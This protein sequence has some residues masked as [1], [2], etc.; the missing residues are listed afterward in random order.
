MNQISLHPRDTGHFQD[1]CK[2]GRFLDLQYF[3]HSND[4][5]KFFAVFL[6]V[7]LCCRNMQQSWIQNMA[8]PICSTCFFVFFALFNKNNNLTVMTN[9]MTQIE[10]M[11][12][13]KHIH[14]QVK[15]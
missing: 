2:K 1:Q 10:R 13:A 11:S 12:L 6:F 9:I 5:K 8:L 15:F 4:I 14:I 3:S 7:T